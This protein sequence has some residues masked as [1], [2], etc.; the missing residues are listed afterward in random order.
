MSVKQTVL[1][2]VGWSFG[3][4]IIVQIVTWAMTLVVIQL[5]RARV[6]LPGQTSGDLRSGLR[7]HELAWV[8]RVP[9]RASLSGT[10]G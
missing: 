5:P 1:S 4:K 9:T 3:I 2:A 10:Y 7:Q 6:A 8:V